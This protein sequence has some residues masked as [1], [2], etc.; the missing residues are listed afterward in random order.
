MVLEVEKQIAVL[1]KKAKSNAELKKEN[2]V[3]KQEGKA[4]KARREWVC[5]WRLVDGDGNQKLN[6]SSTHAIVRFLLPMVDIK[7]ELKMKD[8]TSMKACVKWLEKIKCGMTWDEHMN[9]A[10]DEKMATYEEIWQAENDNSVVGAAPLF[11]LGSV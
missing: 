11:E 1:D 7:G 9:A 8:F 2:D 5:E 10:A 6:W 4:Q 3:M